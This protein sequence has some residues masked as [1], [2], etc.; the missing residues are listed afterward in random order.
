MAVSL[1]FLLYTLLRSV[2]TFGLS[3]AKIFNLSYLLASHVI[4]V[5]FKCQDDTAHLIET[6]QLEKFLGQRILW[7]ILCG[8]VLALIR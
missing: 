3:Q 4:L 1:R 6:S 2:E 8:I 5:S 7:A